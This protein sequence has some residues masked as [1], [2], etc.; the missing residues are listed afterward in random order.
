MTTPRL[1]AQCQRPALLAI[2]GGLLLMAA[3]S[4]RSSRLAVIDPERLQRESK[5]ISAAM[6]R[7]SDPARQLVDRIQAQQASLSK[8]LDAFNKQKSVLS[9]AAATQRATELQKRSQEIQE[10]S[11]QLKEQMDKAGAENLLPIRQRVGK[12]VED[13]AHARNLDLVLPV[14]SVIYHADDLDLTDAVIAALD[15]GAKAKG[16]N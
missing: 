3:A 1:I 2:L 12:A 9:E 10:L 6:A 11:R 7:V 16:A 13:L 4:D 8:D 14:D 15:S 5:T